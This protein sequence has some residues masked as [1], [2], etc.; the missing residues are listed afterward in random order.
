MALKELK[1]N[2]KEQI[3]DTVKDIKIAYIG[4]GSQGWAKRL[5]SDLALESKISGT[6]A[7]YDINFKAALD[8]EKV[9][10]LLS[11]HPD[12]KG[13]WHY[14]AVQ[15]IQEALQG[16]DFVIIS[17]LPGSFQAMGSDVHQPEKYGIYQSVGDTAGPGGLMRACRTIPI[18]ADIANHIKALA[19]NAWVINYTNPMSLCTRTLYEIFP[20]IKAFGCCH[21]VFHTQELLAHMVTDLLEIEV[22][23]R[24]EIKINV[25]GINHFTWIN[26]AS[27][28]N[29]DLMPL[30]QT[31]V[32]KYYEEGY[33]IKKGA[34]RESVFESCNRVKFDL[35]KRY[36][37]IAA[38]GDRHLAEFM[39]PWYLK[40]PETVKAWKFRLTPVD[41]RIQD[42]QEKIN[43]NQK[44]LSGEEQLEVR[45]SGEEGVEMILALLGMGDLVTNVNLPNQGQIAG[46]PLGSVVET[47]ALIRK[48]SVLPVMA[49]QL[50]LDIHNMVQRHVYNQESV[51]QAALNKDK[52]LAFNAFI[53]E[54]LVANISRYKAEKLFNEMIENTKDYLPGWDI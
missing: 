12:V 6:V 29:I 42:Q 4:G 37:L 24:K 27:Y 48:D 47:N 21:E 46:L 3:E 34:W 36:G 19:P 9:G 33:E 30:Y 1:E 17:I 8:N 31:F 26:R 41:F 51:L 52:Q 49:G 50:P 2:N 7:L 14:Q 43:K 18:Y 45:P 25:L 54:P 13:K 5:M 28:K 22:K 20:E 32:D 35:F 23:S 16:A 40:D 10:N 38:A 39:P 15:T 53:N 44:L 11:K